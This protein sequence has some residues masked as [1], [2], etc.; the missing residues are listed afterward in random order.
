MVSAERFQQAVAWLR[1]RRLAGVSFECSRCYGRIVAGL[2][3]LG[4]LS[5]R[6]QNDMWIASIAIQNDATLLTRNEADFHD[7]SGLRVLSY[8]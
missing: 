5:G 3:R 4:K 7:I 2:R 8:G 6:S 1:L